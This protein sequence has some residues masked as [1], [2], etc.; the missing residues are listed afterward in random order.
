MCPRCADWA[1]DRPIARRAVLPPTECLH[2]VTNG[3]P[4]ARLHVGVRTWRP[5]IP[6]GEYFE[7][8]TPEMAALQPLALGQSLQVLNELGLEH[9]GARHEGTVAPQL[10]Y[11]NTCVRGG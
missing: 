3:E 4:L 8:I 9:E 10:S 7:R 5:K 11:L 2:R 6:A 1:G